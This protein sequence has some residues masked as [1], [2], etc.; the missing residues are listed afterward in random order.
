MPSNILSGKILLDINQIGVVALDKIIIVIRPNGLTKLDLY[1]KIKAKGYKV[2][3]FTDKI[4]ENL[5]DIS[6]FIVEVDTT[7]T[8]IL[9]NE[10]INFTLS[11]KEVAAIT[12]FTEFAIEQAALAAEILNLPGPTY[13]AIKICRSK[14]LT[15]DNLKNLPI[16]APKFKLVKNPSD[17]KEFL[18]EVQSSVIIKPLNCAGALGVLRIDNIDE[19]DEKFSSL[20]K[21]ENP[22]FSALLGQEFQQMWLAEEYIDGYEISVESYTVKGETHVVAIHDKLDAVEAPYFLEEF[23]ITPSLRIGQE[24]TN[25]IINSVKVI[26]KSVGFENGITH[27]EFRIKDNVPYLVEINARPGGGLIVESTYY[28]TGINLLEMNV[29]IAVG[30][31]IV[32]K[33]ECHL[34]TVFKCITPPLGKIKSITGADYSTLDPEVK[35]YQVKS[36][37]GDVV[38]NRSS[39]Q[40]VN[41]LLTGNEMPQIINKINEMANKIIIEVEDD[42]GSN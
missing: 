26:L 21:L 4:Q 39:T 1:S 13:K 24:L 41:I 7:K 3:L 38:L 22:E 10:I 34:P 23:F 11:N 20:V 42:D 35:Y 9:L 19:I 27:I 2:V 8:D 33:P 6:D 40:A 17:I 18:E 32:E 36:K 25:T 16:P 29:D 37:V 14:F 30:E 28:S 15:R 31:S 12:S 5:R